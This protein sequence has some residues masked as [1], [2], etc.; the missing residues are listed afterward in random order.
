MVS[1][2]FFTGFCF[3][4]GALLMSVTWEYPAQVRDVS[5]RADVRDIYVD[6]L[7]SGWS[8]W[9]W[10]STLDFDNT[11]PVHAG[12]ASV[13]VTYDQ[14]W[15]GVYLNTSTLIPGNS[16][17][18][19]HFWIHGGTTGGHQMT[20]MLVDGDLTFVA[21]SVNVPTAAGAWTEVNLQISALGQPEAISGIVWQDTSGGAQP[22]FYLDDI[23]LVRNEKL[24]APEPCLIYKPGPNLSI[25]AGASLHTI[26]PD[27]YGMNH[28]DAA[29]AEDLSLPVRR[30]GGN[31]TTRYSWM[32][33]TSN[34]ASDWFFENIPYD[35]SDPGQLPDGSRSDQFVEQNL[36]TG[37]DS[38]IT[39]PLIGWTP[40]AR[41]LDC[42][43]SVSKYGPQQE[44]DP[45]YPDAGNGV[46]PDGTLMTGNDPLDTSAVIDETFVQG[47]I[48]HLK[49]KYGPGG[50]RYY[51]LDNEPMLWNSTHRDVHPEA[52]SYDD[53]RDLTYQ[54]ASAIKA[55][56]PGALT[57]GPVAWGWT[58]YFYSALDAEPGGSWWL[59]PQDRNAH[60][61]VPFVDWYLQQMLAYE[62]THGTRILDYLDLHGYPQAPGVALSGAG[63]AATQALR[64]RST[65][66]LWDPTYVDESWIAEPVRLIPRMRDWVN[67]NYPGTK[68]AV[69]EYN[70]G[71]LD[72]IN[73]ALA[74]ADVLGI[75]GRE[76]LDLAT[77]WEGPAF[78]DPVSFA[79]RIYRNYDGL[80]STFG[81]LA[82]SCVSSDQGQLSVY[83]ALRDTDGALTIVVINKTQKQLHSKVTLSGFTP[84][85]D[86]LVYRYSEADLSAI[87]RLADQPVG[88]SG[89]ERSFEAESITLIVVL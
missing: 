67:Q 74:Q 33:D 21:S 68:L 29:L 85:G 25:D 87:R 84:S 38:L 56:D 39:V 47:W 72:H 8:D 26:S 50:V 63:N 64:L 9:S 73:G 70:W 58:A 60:G 3:F 69:T 27:I 41:Q 37:T 11:D 57:L 13:A 6:A 14:A 31:S 43:F 65:R 49:N 10:G 1:R 23:S 19:L 81:N 78:D 30:W 83:G 48:N 40:K 46:H 24:H 76:G 35:N 71:A 62:Q 32:N 53:M 16:Y 66:C 36:A 18:K 15:A 82:V 61:G 22:T 7:E 45:W 28:A 59:N 2:H 77:L 34:R 12:S 79:F 75:F 44:V 52:T 54:Y 17:Q 20:V 5:A 51:N 4:T 80:K 89:F 88:T 42:G 86:A 55:A